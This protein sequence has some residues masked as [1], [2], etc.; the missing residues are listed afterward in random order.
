MAQSL[1][2][3]T[4]VRALTS[5]ST[6]NKKYKLCEPTL[7]MR[8]QVLR[9]PS[10]MRVQVLRAPSTYE[11]ASSA[12][13]LSYESASSADPLSYESESSGGTPTAQN[14][15]VPWNPNPRKSEHSGCRVALRVGGGHAASVQ[16]VARL[17]PA[18]PCD[19]GPHGVCDWGVRPQGS[20]GQA[21]QVPSRAPC[22]LAS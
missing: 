2:R 19:R 13:P 9:A 16:G 10:H 7:H 11:G 14:S 22:T 3:G 12:S 4:G 17:L 21:L 15:R 8:V 1:D 18:S 20:G 6:C 5:P